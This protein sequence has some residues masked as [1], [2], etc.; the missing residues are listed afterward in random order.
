MAQGEHLE[1]EAWPL[2]YC[3]AATFTAFTAT[4]MPFRIGYPTVE[5]K[6]S[7]RRDLPSVLVRN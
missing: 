5:A 1:R 6:P 7:P 4:L 3:E 2:K